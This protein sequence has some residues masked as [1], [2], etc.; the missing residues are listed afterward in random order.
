M[1]D[2]LALTPTEWVMIRNSAPEVLEVEAEYGANGDPPPKHFHPAQDERFRVLDGTLRTR[3]DGIERDLAV[4]DVIEIPRGAVHQ[5]WNPAASPAKVSWETRPG[6]RTE[7]WFRDLAAASAK[8][9]GRPS[10]LAF[11]VLLDEYGD[12]FRLAG[13]QPP[14]RIAFAALAVVGRARGHRVQDG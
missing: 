7:Q 12:V 13:P 8:A 14:L 11:A 9:G 4:G 2:R 10:V 3:V 5:M 6:G 1:S